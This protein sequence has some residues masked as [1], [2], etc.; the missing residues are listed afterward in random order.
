MEQF[1]AEPPKH[2]YTYTDFVGEFV[3]WC[4][5]R[6]SGAVGLPNFLIYSYYFWKKDCE[7]GYIIKNNIIK[8][9]KIIYRLNQ[10]FF[11]VVSNLPSQTFLFFDKS[12][13]VS[14]FGGKQYPDGTYIIDY[15]DEL[16]EY[17]KRFYGSC[18]RSS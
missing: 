1:N 2:L 12:Y 13:L 10:P 4:C 9:Q 5:N 15:I 18:V 6:T 7:S 16:L 3:S 17:Q 11:E 8:K 14:L